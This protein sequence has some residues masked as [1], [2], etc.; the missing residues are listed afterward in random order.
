MVDRFRQSACWVEP[1]EQ[2]RRDLW[3]AD[4]KR[5]IQVHCKRERQQ[6]S[7][8]DNVRR[9]VGCG[10]S[11]STG[12]YI[13]N[14]ILWNLWDA[15]FNRPECK[16]RNCTVYLVDHFRQPA[17]WTEPGAEHRRDLWYTDGKRDIQL[18]CKRERQ[19]QSHPDNVRRDIGSGDIDSTGDYI[20]NATLRN[21][22]HALLNGPECKWG[23]CTV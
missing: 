10:G 11:D 3:Y 13:F 12:D 7:H 5:D 21:L 2:H 6:Q 15:L 8:P 16:W 14:A 4:G 23:S 19:Q 18:H 17:C 22:W 1:G 9:D 20:F